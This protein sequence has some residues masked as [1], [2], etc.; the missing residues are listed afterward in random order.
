MAANIF[1]AVHIEIYGPLPASDVGYTH[2]LTM[3]DN[4]SKWTI[5]SPL[6]DTRSTSLITAIHQDLF[7]IYG[8]PRKIVSDRGANLLSD[9]IE[10]FF[11]L[12]KG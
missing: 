2:I 9:E 10:D 3:C 8:Y 1:D 6:K 4:L 7:C 11:H 12:L 5:A